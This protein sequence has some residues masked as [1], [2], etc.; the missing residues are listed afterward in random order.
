MDDY[1]KVLQKNLAGLLKQRG[2]NVRRQLPA[3]YV[4][5]TKKGLKV[6]WRTVQYM[7]EPNGPSP[8][9]DALVAVAGALD[10]QVA[11]LLD[12]DLL[13]RKG[14]A[15]FE[16][17][18]EAEVSRRMVARMQELQ[19]SVAALLRMQANATGVSGVSPDPGSDQQAPGEGEGNRTKRAG[20]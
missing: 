11:D 10:L 13:R 12:P 1:R 3:H 6:S 19:D 2:Y 7:M 17:A 15:E 5:G 9:L 8:S 16:I 14:P 4:A 18:V 20:D